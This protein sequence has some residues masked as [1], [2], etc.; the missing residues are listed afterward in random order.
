MN[1]KKC[2]YPGLR[3]YNEEESIFFKGRDVH[4]RKIIKQL[5]ERKI[6][7]ITGASGDGK[8]SLVYAGVIPN[9]R[10]GFFHAEY[11]NW[12]FVDFKPERNPLYTLAESLSKQLKKDV[13][14]IE[15]KLSNGFSALVELY[16]T[17]EYYIDESSEQWINAS[18][19][20]QKTRRNKSANLFILADQFEE[21]FTN[22]ENYRS[23]KPSVDAYTTVNLLLETANIAL[24]DNLPIYIVFTMRSD[25][26]SQCVAFKG[27]P[28]MIG[29]SQFFV[30][31]LKRNEIRQ[32]IEEP[33]LLSG[34]KVSNR[35][36]EV[37][38]NELRDGFDQLPVLQHALHQLWTLADNGNN[39]LDLIHL[40]RLGGMPSRY[41]ASKDKL[42][43]DQW[44]QNLPE[45]RK[46]FFHNPG[47]N[48]IL[49]LSGR[50][51][52]YYIIGKKL[53]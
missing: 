49:C 50:N 38:I 10:A 4:I 47:L 52:I 32:V 42:E 20:E 48:N 34:G 13:D 29:F 53:I 9:A 23:G 26:I 36:T 21:F 40:A 31:R 43:F 11:N 35:L 6:I 25:F 1:K 22:N 39:E 15:K 30:P 19:Y 28:E 51:N 27:L 7:M 8:S 17:S 16:K 37:L 41:L 33:A 46:T 18:S 5:E 24:H 3:P 2:P 44:F 45:Y 14:E 12:L